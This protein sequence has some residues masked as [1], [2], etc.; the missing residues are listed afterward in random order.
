MS[1]RY[2]GNVRELRNLLAQSAL[3][4]RS[5]RIEAAHVSEV[6]EERDA[7]RRRVSPAEALSLL[8]AYDGN[9]SAVARHAN[10]P[11]STLRDL[12]KRSQSED[13][14]QLRQSF[15]GRE[16]RLRLACSST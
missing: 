15:G 6:L 14:T 16:H 13:V 12:I 7:V 11:R 2:R 4:T 3:R 8:A 1:R 9:I 5:G 10:L